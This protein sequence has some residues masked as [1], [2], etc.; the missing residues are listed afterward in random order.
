VDAERGTSRSESL[1]WQ[2][3]RSAGMQLFVGVSRERGDGP[4][5]SRA[6]QAFVKLQLDVSE[7]RAMW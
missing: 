6:T 7:L 2:W 1:T 3:R 5:G 4:D